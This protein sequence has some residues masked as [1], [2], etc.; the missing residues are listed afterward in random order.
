[1]T[2]S[3]AGPPRPKAAYLVAEWPFPPTS[4]GARR[5][6]NIAEVLGERFDLTVVSAD[7]DSA[8]PGWS[9]AS[10]RFLARRRSRVALVSDGFGSIARGRHALLIR[11]IR[12]GLPE[13]FAAWLTTTKPELVVLGRPMLDP[14]IQAARDAG[15][16]VI[17]DADEGL[18]R[19]ARS[20]ARASHSSPRTRLRAVVEGTLVLDRM[21]R[22]A[23][24]SADQLWVSSEREKAFL[25]RIVEP[26]RIHVVANAVAVPAELPAPVPI[27][28]V[29]FVGWYRYPPNEAAALEL[30]RSIMPAIR[31]A[32]GPHHLEIIGPHPTTKMHRE[33]D[34]LG[35]TTITGEVPE[36]V[37]AL[38]DAGI[39]LV[40]LRSGGGTRVKILEAAAAGVPVIS[41]ALGIEGLGMTPGQNVLV[42]EDA[43]GFAAQVTALTSPDGPLP[44]ITRNAFE[45]V[46]D[47]HS[48]A[49]LGAD[50]EAAMGSLQPK[51][52]P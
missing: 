6:A 37:P 27:Q 33:A 52:R 35:D 30:M 19:V 21:E 24:P 18:G 44:E 13:R 16:R 11:S 12:A 34:R 26:A 7:R 10:T 31:A 20:V 15:A 25:S 5:A 17:V 46:R 8:I 50:I 23:Y 28:A 22:A 40:P 38:R 49:S 36:V 42:A 2:L 47:T 4:G 39:L 9:D 45:F 41:T 48:L 43:D 14:F 29:A 1:M 3:S 51:G 32:G